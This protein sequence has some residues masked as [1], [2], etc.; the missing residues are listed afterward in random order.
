LFQYLPADV[1][2]DDAVVIVDSDDAYLLGVLTSRTHLH[3]AIRAGGW[4]GVG[5]DSRYLKSK[6]FDPYPFPDAT[7]WQRAAI[8]AL[9]GE[10]D[11]T[12]RAALDDTPGLTL[13]ELYNWRE[14]IAAGEEL[15]NQDEARAIS[16]RAYI[17]HRLHGQI[18]EAVAEAYGW[19]SDLAPAEIVARLV[20][21]NTERAAEEAGGHV[22]WLRP[23][24]QLPRFGPKETEH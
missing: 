11:A 8:S 14:R 21:L 3:W 6:V 13:T 16:A 22:R 24:Y 5:N 18:D 1:L 10:L 4:L 9:A 7:D 17:V 23:D 12:R 15:V 19:P 2:C 20:A